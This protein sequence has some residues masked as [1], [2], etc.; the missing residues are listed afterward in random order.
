[1]IRLRDGL[2]EHFTRG[3]TCQESNERKHRLVGLRIDMRPASR[4]TSDTA[5][6]RSLSSW[7]PVP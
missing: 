4:A 3:L 2:V 7:R 5:R 6:S 1:M